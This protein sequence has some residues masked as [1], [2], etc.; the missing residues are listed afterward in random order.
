M[1][2][3]YQIWIGG[4]YHMSGGIRALHVLRDELRARGADAWMTYERTH[5]DAITVYPEIVGGN[6]LNSPY[7]I[8][9]LLN[10][11]DHPEPSWAWEAGMGD[12][13]LLTVD[14]LERDLWT[15]YEGPRSGVAFWIGKGNLDASVLP[16]GAEQ[17][18][19]SNYT[20]R[21]ALAQRLR[22]LDHLISFDAFTCMNL[23]AV[24]V[25]TPVLIY[26]T[27]PQ[28]SRPQVEAHGWTPHGVAWNPQQLDNA[29]ATVADAYP[30]YQALRDTFK[31]RIDAFLHAS[32]ALYPA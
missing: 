30:H 2:R 19:R 18:S 4:Y 5:P 25:G 32:Q 21:P 26:P 15:P 10:R 31:A 16:D 12:H 13:P 1:V 23:E 11:A 6:P 14:L 27:D 3:P 7:P 17:I 8:K 9:W 22:T 29:R 20:T 24:C 28:W